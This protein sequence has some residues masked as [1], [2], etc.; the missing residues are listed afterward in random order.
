MTG[1][2]DQS[3][4]KL[5]NSTDTAEAYYGEGVPEF[6]GAMELIEEKGVGSGLEFIKER[7]RVF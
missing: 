4:E 5:E 2:P 7:S 1:V 6:K 3:N